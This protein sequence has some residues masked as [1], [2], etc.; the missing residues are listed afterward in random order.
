M[1]VSVE[2]TGG[3]QRRMKV[4]LPEDQINQ[5]VESRLQN[6]TRTAIAMIESHAVGD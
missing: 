1:Q 6:M 4:E 2:S 5:A 3:L